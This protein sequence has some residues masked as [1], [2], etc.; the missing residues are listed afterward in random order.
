MAREVHFLVVDT[1]SAEL[2]KLGQLF[3]KAVK[4]NE[5]L[6]FRL[7]CLVVGWGESR[8]IIKARIFVVC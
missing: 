3:G 4:V 6:L 8:T 2:K 5:D 7:K 1:I